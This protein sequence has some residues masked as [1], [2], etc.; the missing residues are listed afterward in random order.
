MAQRVMVHVKKS[1]ISGMW[2]A[3]VC[4]GVW[5]IEEYGCISFL[6]LCRSMGLTLVVEGI[7]KRTRSVKTRSVRRVSSRR[8]SCGGSVCV[9]SMVSRR[10]GYAVVVPCSLSTCGLSK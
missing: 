8:L 10:L 4:R 5:M 1:C 3:R 2:F 6:S 7:G 9:G